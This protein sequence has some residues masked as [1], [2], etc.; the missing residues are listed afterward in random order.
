ML[1]KAFILPIQFIGQW[2]ALLSSLQHEFKLCSALGDFF[3]FH[4]AV[5]TAELRAVGYALAG[6]EHFQISNGNQLAIA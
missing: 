6:I 3:N 5:F 2:A 4:H 1:K